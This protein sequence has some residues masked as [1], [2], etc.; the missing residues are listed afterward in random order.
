MIISNYLKRKY[1]EIENS[2]NPYVEIRRCKVRLQKWIKK[3]L[4]GRI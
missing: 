4:R 3:L 1:W 2:K